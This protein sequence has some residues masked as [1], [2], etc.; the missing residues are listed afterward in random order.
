MFKWLRDTLLSSEEGFEIGLNR[1]TNFIEFGK[2]F[3]NNS[4][5]T[6]E[7]LLLFESENMLLRAEGFNKNSMSR[8]LDLDMNCRRLFANIYGGSDFKYNSKFDKK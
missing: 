7:L 5:E 2:S 6:A 3:D 1:N 8:L 4:T